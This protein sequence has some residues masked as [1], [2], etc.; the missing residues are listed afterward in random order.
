[1]AAP[2]IRELFANGVAE[3]NKLGV[4][5]AAADVK[6]LLSEACGTPP[7]E[8]A[9]ADRAA[10]EEEAARFRACL[11]RR[12][13]GEPVQYILGHSYFYDLELEVTP[14]VLI[15]RPETEV[16]V[17]RV[18]EML[19]QGGTLLDL[20]TGSGAIALSV[21]CRRRDAGVTAADISCAAL[22]V[23]RRNARKVGAEVEFV[24]SDLFSALGT[25]R[26]DVVAANLP[27][28]PEEDRP[29]LAPEVA[30]REPAVALF[31]AD[32]GFAVIDRALEALPQ[33]LAPG[34][35]AIFELDPRQAA[36]AAEKLEKIGFAAAIR[37]DLAGRERFAEGV[38]K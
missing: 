6:L 11:R 22:E 36:R 15:P 35:F 30:L 31:A 5:S 18:L 4:G 21:A 1:M 38:K 34:G 27:Y 23:A 2:T 12:I 19:P 37:R 14:D 24:L 10:T 20:G 28:V 17:D 3:L 9:F 16:L 29:H 33:H 7:A 26:F 32:G 13:G 8:A 25:R